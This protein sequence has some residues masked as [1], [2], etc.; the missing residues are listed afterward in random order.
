[1]TNVVFFPAFVS[2]DDGHWHHGERFATLRAMVQSLTP[3]D[4]QRL[5]AWDRR[6]RGRADSHR[7]A[8]LGATSH[9]RAIRWQPHIRPALP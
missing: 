5:I 8:T 1:M 2:R 3:K 7:G 9:D 4:Y 6:R